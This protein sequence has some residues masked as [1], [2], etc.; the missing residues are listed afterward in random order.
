MSKPL[1]VPTV[2]QSVERSAWLSAVARAAE[3]RAP[4]VVDRHAP[5]ST[6][7]GL[8]WFRGR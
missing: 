1:A 3:T 8:S 2:P 5:T 6:L 4:H 7:A